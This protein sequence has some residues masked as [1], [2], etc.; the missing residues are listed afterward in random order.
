MSSAVEV[1][2][3]SYWHKI[4]FRI[5]SKVQCPYVSQPFH[6]SLSL[7]TCLCSDYHYNLNNE[8]RGEWVSVM[9]TVEEIHKMAQILTVPRTKFI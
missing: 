3:F 1:A 8:G 9:N 6:Q 2:V 4:T 7:Y 5:E